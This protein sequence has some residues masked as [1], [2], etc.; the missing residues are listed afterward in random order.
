MKR[1]PAEREK[2]IAKKATNK[3]LISKIYKQL[4]K[5][6]IKKAK[7]PIKKWAED[8]NSFFSKEDMQMPNKYMKRCSTSPIIREMPIKTTELSP[9]TSQNGH[10]Q[11]STNNMCQRGC[12]ETRTVIYCFWGCKLTQPLWRTVQRF[13]KN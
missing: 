7:N 2:I 11:K 13:L 8:V 12:G 6:N 3:E 9:H 10:H 5:L 4:M 1:K